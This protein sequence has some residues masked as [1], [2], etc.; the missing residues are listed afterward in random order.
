MDIGYV[1][2]SLEP[3]KAI[4]GTVKACLR[5]RSLSSPIACL[6]AA[7][8]LHGRVQYYNVAVMLKILFTYIILYLLNKYRSLFSIHLLYFKTVICSM[9]LCCRRYME[10][11]ANRL[12]ALPTFES[13]MRTSDDQKTVNP[14][15][16]GKS[17]LYEID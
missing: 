2:K 15:Q 17:T 1:L 9:R 5:M 8:C 11:E 6:V 3:H 12:D 13:N 7:C 14:E 4:E 16:T 10:C